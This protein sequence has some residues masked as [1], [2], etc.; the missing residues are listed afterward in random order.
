MVRIYQQQIQDHVN[1]NSSKSLKTRSTETALHIFISSRY[2]P[3]PF[4]EEGKG[5]KKPNENSEMIEKTSL[6][7]SHQKHLLSETTIRGPE[8]KLTAPKSYSFL[9]CVYVL[10][11]ALR[12]SR[13]L[14]SQGLWRQRMARCLM[15]RTQPDS[16]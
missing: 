11:A 3:R 16:E 5:S 7:I 2:S 14:G 10:W 9:P 4:R 8:H 12:Y 1:R 6:Q 15:M 13:R